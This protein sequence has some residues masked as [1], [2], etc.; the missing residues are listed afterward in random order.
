ML[1]GLIL[2]ECLTKSFLTKFSLLLNLN[3]ISTI[4]PIVYIFFVFRFIII[5]SKKDKFKIL[6]SRLLVHTVAYAKSYQDK[7]S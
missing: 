7:L 2:T 5:K 3:L 6:F 1:S 4:F